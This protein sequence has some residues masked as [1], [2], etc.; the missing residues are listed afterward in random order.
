VFVIASQCYFPFSALKFIHIAPTIQRN[1]A[2]KKKNITHFIIQS[3]ENAFGINMHCNEVNCF[4]VIINF[5]KFNANIIEMVMFEYKCH[6][7][8]QAAFLTSDT[9]FYD[10]KNA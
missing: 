10:G 8:L 9:K 7:G 6:N 2:L 1:F 3:F 4:F 5:S